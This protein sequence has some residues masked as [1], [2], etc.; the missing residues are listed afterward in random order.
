[1]GPGAFHDVDRLT[2]FADYRLPQ[3]LRGAGLMRLP[4]PLAR[5]IEA[6]EVLAEGCPE[7]VEIRAATVH[8]GE[9]IRQ[10]LSARYPGITALQ[11]DHALWRS[12]VLGRARLPP[13]HR[14]RTTDY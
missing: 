11:V 5:R 13:F 4:E 10:A 9:L 2:V 1:R 7:E 8:L 6:G 14:C 12:G 3:V